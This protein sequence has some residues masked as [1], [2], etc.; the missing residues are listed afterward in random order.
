MAKIKITIST[1]YKAQ[2][3]FCV[4]ISKNEKPTY[5]VYRLD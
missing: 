2:Q 3:I 5:F 1:S 4:K